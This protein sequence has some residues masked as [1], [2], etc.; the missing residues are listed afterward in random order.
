M[1]SSSNMSG[2]EITIDEVKHAWTDMGRKMWNV[3]YTHGPTQ[4]RY[5][6]RTWARDELDA[7]TI[8]MKKLEGAS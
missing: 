6:M 1:P 8:A 3:T 7:Y 5:V 2:D 4:G